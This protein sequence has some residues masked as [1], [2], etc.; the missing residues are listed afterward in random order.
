MLPRALWNPIAEYQSSELRQDLQDIAIN[1]S[2]R[3]D[4]FSRGAR[5]SFVRESDAFSKL[6]LVLI[7][8]PDT[9][10]TTTIKT[11]AGELSLSQELVAEVVGALEAGPQAIADL[12]TLPAMKQQ[13][14]IGALQILLMLLHAHYIGVEALEVGP[15]ENAQRLNAVLAQA[16]ANGAPYDHIA[17]PVL[18]SAIRVSI[19]DLLLI[20][21]WLES[22]SKADAAALAKGLL[23]RLANLGRKL[24]DGGQEFA[25]AEAEQRAE[26]LATRFLKKSLPH[27][28]QLGAFA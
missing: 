23:A 10:K 18:G 25:G 28:R 16:A 9:G 4:I 26:E 2:F 3:R 6:R 7:V 22:S 20:D 13:S 17:S 11:A 27:W 15:A 8:P 21:C 14:G 1:Q 24:K 5:R 19:A 12:L